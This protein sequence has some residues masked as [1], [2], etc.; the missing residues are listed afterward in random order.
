ML[1]FLSALSQKLLKYVYSQREN[2][3]YVTPLN[4]DSRSH[5]SDFFYFCLSSGALVTASAFGRPWPCLYVFLLS[6]PSSTLLERGD[7]CVEV[8]DFG[9]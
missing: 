5:A 2:V 1:P 8:S 6:G 4:Y 7:V 9:L 3:I